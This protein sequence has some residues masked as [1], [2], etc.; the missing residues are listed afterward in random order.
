[1]ANLGGHDNNILALAGNLSYT[2][3]STEGLPTV[4]SAPV[5]DMF[6]GQMAAFGALAALIGRKDGLG[7]QR[8]D[9][10]MLHAGFFLNFLEIAARNG[11]D[12]VAP[13]PE[14]G[15]MNGGRADYRVYKT[16]DEKHIFFG[17]IEPWSL[18]KFLTES[19]KGHLM[20]LIDDPEGLTVALKSVFA[21]KNQEEWVHAGAMLDV[22]I[23]AVNSM[24][25]AIGHP[26]VRSLGLIQTVVDPI[27]GN[28]Q[29][30][31]YPLGFG[32]DSKQPELPD[33]APA[34]GQHTHEILS[35]LLGYD[36][37]T[38]QHLAKN[39]TVLLGGN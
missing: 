33:S 1:M 34:I 6:A 20:S 15:W 2:Q 5:A 9:A 14:K 23:T 19:G 37:Q 28:L 17:P 31:G 26:Q 39:G 18:R 4:F 21:E 32:A 22:C 7:G 27:Y 35:K 25:E 10:S 24:E 38:I 29:M 3:R 36:D 11:A 13:A 12:Y 16:K 8:L 30:P